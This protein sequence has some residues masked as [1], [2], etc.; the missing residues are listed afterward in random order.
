MATARLKSEKVT[1]A[2]L[3]LK[4]AST[5]A[6]VKPSKN[7]LSYMKALVEL[8][9][10][11]T[12]PILLVE[13]SKLKYVKYGFGDAYGGGFRG[14]IEGEAV[15]DIETGTWNDI[16]SQKSSNFRELINFCT[17]CKMML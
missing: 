13:S 10:S 2:E 12:P 16:G 6:T 15:L 14:T 7:L 8:M 4:S 5:L 9:I 1:G 17:I 11:K 3:F